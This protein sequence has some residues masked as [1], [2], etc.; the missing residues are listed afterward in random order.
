MVIALQAP[1]FFDPLEELGESWDQTEGTKQDDNET[2]QR[3]T[4]HDVTVTDTLV[5]NH[6]WV[7]EEEDGM[8]SC[9]DKTLKGFWRRNFFFWYHII[10]VFSFKSYAWKSFRV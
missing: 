1:F 5:V 9:F 10:P 7:S 4:E 2:N 3:V 8:G 6:L